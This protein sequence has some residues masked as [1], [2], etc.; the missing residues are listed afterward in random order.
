MNNPFWMYLSNC[1]T[2]T[3]KYLLNSLLGDQL[4]IK[5]FQVFLQI[6]F[7]A[8]LKNQVKVI[9]CLQVII[10]LDNV[11]MRY[12]FYQRNL[13][14]DLLFLILSYFVQTNHFDCEF[15]NVILFHCLKNL[16]RCPTADAFRQSIRADFLNYVRHFYREILV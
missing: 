16:R 8:I 7:F 13:L 4:S 12:V 15:L 5:F 3:E 2:N 10:Q 14:M 9:R 6:P 1:I 11:R